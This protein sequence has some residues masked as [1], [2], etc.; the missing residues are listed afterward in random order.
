M[1]EITFG[2]DLCLDALVIPS[3]AADR[4]ID[5]AN[6]AQLKI[7]LYMLKMRGREEIT[8]SSIAD[9]FNYT[10]ADVKRAIKFWNGK[11]SCKQP[12]AKQG[13]NVVAFSV[14]P[15]YSKEKLV[16]FTKSPDV[17][18]LLFV[19]EQY[20]GRP[21]SP[22]DISS[23]LYMYDEMGF[24]AELIEYLFEYCIG[25]NKKSLRSIEMVASEWKESGI[26]SVADAKK[27]T[28]RV[29][30]EMSEVLA[31][32]G[33]DNS[34]QPVDAEIAYV[35]KWTENY[36]YGMD[37][38]SQACQRTVLTI[39]KPSFRYANSIIKSWHDA[40]VKTVAE[41]LRLDDEHRQKKVADV[42]EGKNV[43]K[44]AAKVPEQAKQVS[45]KFHN[46]TEREYDYSSLMKDVM[47]N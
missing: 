6:E 3:A 30:K 33:Y 24:S 2:S 25:N 39:G 42:S 17:S 29:P 18:Q 8:I 1:D 10:E 21:F 36:G 27:M 9:Y 41:I 35:R 15:S 4:M 46:F 26:K 14:R 37:I 31:A 28:R 38:I 5:E 23:I 32:F 11:S 12:K 45:Q 47:E 13:D 22:D 43:A 34:H 20:M 44:R 40:G 7:Y 19:A 16:E